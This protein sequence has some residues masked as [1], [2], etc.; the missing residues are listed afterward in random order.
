VKEE[1]MAE[2][3][4]KKAEKKEMIEF[5]DVPFD[6]LVLDPG[7]PRSVTDQ[8]K[9][10]LER[11]LEHYGFVNPVIAYRL[12]PEDAAYAAEV[13][14]Q[15]PAGALLVIAGHQRIPAARAKG[16]DRGPVVVFPFRS[17]REARAYNIADN[18]LQE[19]SAWDFPRLKDRFEDIDDG[20][21]PMDATGFD[22]IER[23]TLAT[24]GK[25]PTDPNTEWEGMPEFKNE[26]GAIKTLYVH[27]KTEDDV[28]NFSKFIGQE[29]GKYTKYIWYPKQER[30]DMK[31]KGFKS[32]S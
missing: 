18:K 9:S 1:N 22:E 21:F 26:P 8:G 17:L 30:E 29:I 20:S 19:M 6:D 3:K 14:I 31:S 28:I 16:L 2:T 5:R 23:E 27:F 25:K 10:R 7:N 12:R 32:E 4:P 11:S 24:W 15:A 13:G